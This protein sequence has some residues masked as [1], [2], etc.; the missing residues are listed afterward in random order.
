MYVCGLSSTCRTS[1]ATVIADLHV[2]LM[3]SFSYSSNNN[4]EWQRCL[5]NASSEHFTAFPVAG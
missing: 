4:P 3:V 1:Q 5:L 2:I